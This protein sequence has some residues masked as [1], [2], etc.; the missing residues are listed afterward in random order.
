[1]KP[2][3]VN[4]TRGNRT[5][6]VFFVLFMA[7]TLILSGPTFATGDETLDE[8]VNSFDDKKADASVDTVGDTLDDVLEGFEDEPKEAEKSPVE[9]DI[10]EGFDDEIKES[11]PERRK[12]EFKPSIFSLNGDAKLG[13]SYNFA[14]DKPQ[15]N[16]TNW[17][18]LSRLRG[19]LHL[20]FS[21]K[22][23]D[24]WQARVSGKGAYD[25]AYSIKGRDDFTDEV[26]DGYEKE[27]ELGE[28][29]LQGIL[30]KNFDVKIGRQIIVWG[31]SDNIRVTDVLNPLDMREPGLTDIE[32]LRLPVA[33]SRLDYYI[34]DWNLTGIAIHEIR[35]NKTPEY[36][37]DF[38]P[39]STPPPHEDKPDSR[40]KN[41]E[42]ATAINGVFSGWD[43]SLY[44]ADYYNDMPHIEL[45][46]AGL[47]PQIEWKH[48]RLKM[49]GAAFN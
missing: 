32:D 3:I 43:I 39:S 8:I 7:F 48:A 35:F 1:M 25:F 5:I 2:D 34:G 28:T 10:L 47:P 46:A 38:Y 49:V 27:L 18:G 40:C 37:S 13:A 31:K 44:W 19:E 22:F 16:E 17:R 12:D 45:V 36:G 41:T 14:H 42:Y 23:S 30:T 4:L 20:K 11:D 6:A 9:D 24:L 21:A 15:G 33:M 29:Y 26:I